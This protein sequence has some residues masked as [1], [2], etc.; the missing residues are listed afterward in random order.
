[1]IKTP[2]EMKKKNYGKKRDSNDW[3]NFSFKYFHIDFFFKSKFQKSPMK[4]NSALFYAFLETVLKD[5]GG[6]LLLHCGSCAELQHHRKRV[7]TPAVLFTFT[8]KLIT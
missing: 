1:M 7:R 8:F 5:G 2:E 6:E 3:G 4:Y